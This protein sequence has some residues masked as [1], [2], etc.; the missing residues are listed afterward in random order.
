MEELRRAW[1]IM[2][3]I[4][5]CQPILIL[6]IILGSIMLVLEFFHSVEKRKGGSREEKTNKS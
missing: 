4:D 3:N 1:N 6:V 2:I 5:S